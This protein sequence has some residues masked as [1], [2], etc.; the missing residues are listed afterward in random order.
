MFHRPLRL[1]PATIEE[2]TGVLDL[3]IRPNIDSIFG[4]VGPISQSAYWSSTSFPP[5]M[6]YGVWVVSFAD[7]SGAGGTR[8]DAPFTYYARAVRGGL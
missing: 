3:S 6:D 2:L 4:P 1:A 7:E 5:A 8:K